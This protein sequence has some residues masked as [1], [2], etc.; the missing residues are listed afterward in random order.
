MRD[1]A[2][3]IYLSTSFGSLINWDKSILSP[4]ESI[5][6]LGLLI[7]S[8]TLSLALPSEKVVSLSFIGRRTLEKGSVSLHN[9]L[10][11]IGSFSW[12]I[13]AV[14]YAQ[15]YYRNLQRFYIFHSKRSNFSQVVSLQLG[16][17]EDISWW[18]HNLSLSKG[19]CYVAKEPDIVIYSDA[20][21]HGRGSTCDEIQSRGSWT[22][23]DCLRH[24]NEL[25]LL[26]AF[27]TLKSLTA[28]STDLAVHIFPD[29]STA[30]CYINKSGGTKSRALCDLARLIVYC[31]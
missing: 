15:A 9:I 1:L 17:R 20:S 6:F 25:K 10:S 24:I 27:Y 13:P 5:E 4:T 22:G 30:V 12:A 28:F 3:A 16:V 29:N 26:A 31:A 8:N 7:K 14:P 21:L 2:V 11:L 19:L 18:L 23:H